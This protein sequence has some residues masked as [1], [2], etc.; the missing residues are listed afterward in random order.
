MAIFGY[1]FLDP[2]RK[3]RIPL[4]RQQYAI[5]Q[6][7]EHRKVKIRDFF[8]EEN[9]PAHRPFDQRKQGSLLLRDC[10]SR[11]WIVASHTEV[12][13]A[14]AKEGLRLLDTLRARGIS[15]HLADL[16][17]DIVFPTK[18]KLIIST[19]ICD[20]VNTLLA[21]LAR[22]ERAG[23]ST[24]ILRA[25][26]LGKKQGR[27]LGGPIGFGW[28]ID[29]EGFII[30]NPEEQRIIKE[31]MKLRQD[32]WSYREISKI[33][34][35]RHGIRLSHEGI[36]K[37]LMNYEKKRETVRRH[38]IARQHELDPRLEEHAPEE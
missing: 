20:V 35:D 32:R 11:D 13:F 22:H 37:L 18:R 14:R 27:Y 38:N 19:G 26:R 33:L 12:L 28:Q 30:E 21:S 6:Y 9:I 10:D 24:A 25:K 31:I 16:G 5:E 4:A 2:N 7:A 29:G 36:R 15:L 23:N 1:I 34:G 17:G 8:I 3:N